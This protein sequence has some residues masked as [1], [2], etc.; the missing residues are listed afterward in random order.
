MDQKRQTGGESR[1]LSLIFA[2]NSF[3]FLK[4]KRKNFLPIPSF[5]TIMDV[6]VVESGAKW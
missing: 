2:E 5:C 4:E 6:Q 1:C 3:S